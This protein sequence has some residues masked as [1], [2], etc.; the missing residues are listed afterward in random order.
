[1]VSLSLTL[2]LIPLNILP[3]QSYMISNLFAITHWSL[4]QLSGDAEI[5]ATPKTLPEIAESD[6]LTPNT[7]NVS[8]TFWAYLGTKFWSLKKNSDCESHSIISDGVNDANFLHFSKLLGLQPKMAAALWLPMP[9]PV[10][11]RRHHCRNL[12]SQLSL[13]HPSSHNRT[14]D[15][16]P[17]PVSSW[18]YYWVLCLSVEI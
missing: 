12:Q 13:D 10:C 1:M 9:L 7:L 16:I 18:S 6:I 15:I 8:S 14:E 3:V 17:T 2:T 4:L 11:H 5:I